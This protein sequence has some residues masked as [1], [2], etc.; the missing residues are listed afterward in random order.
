LLLLAPACSCLLLLAFAY[1]L[2]CL[3]DWYCY[4]Q[5]AGVKGDILF[6]RLT[7]FIPVVYYPQQAKKAKDRGPSPAH[8]L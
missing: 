1:L 6:Q 3:K 4:V 7:F 5:Q 2:I 8:L